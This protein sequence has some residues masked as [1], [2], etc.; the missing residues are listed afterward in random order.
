M[1]FCFVSTALPSKC[2]RDSYV[3][4]S[5]QNLLSPPRQ[6]L[7]HCRIPIFA[8]TEF[9]NQRPLSSRHFINLT[10]GLEALPALHALIPPA[11]LRFTR[12][13]SS[14]CESGAYDKLLC[15]LDNELLF[16]LACGRQCY[17]YDFGSRNKTHGVPRAIFLGVQFIK[18]SLTYLWFHAEAPEKVPSSVM[19][20]GKNAVPFWRDEVMAYRI[21]RDAK[22]RV[23]Y[24]TPFVREMGVRE[25]K[26]EGVY[27]RVSEIDGCKEVHVGLARGWVERTR[28]E[29]ENADFEHEQF[30]EWAEKHHLSVFEADLTG[31][32]LS[33]IQRWMTSAK[34]GKTE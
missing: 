8:A 10:N 23:R 25:V 27:G 15:G 9:S 21:S 29:K 6:L 18:W 4:H 20:R 33:N 24:F 34:D 3:C 2:Y 22:K 16:S 32:K 30:L 11:E 7:P 31:E 5:H 28:I 12:I 1:Q 13:Q 26:L 19:V 17:L 14:H